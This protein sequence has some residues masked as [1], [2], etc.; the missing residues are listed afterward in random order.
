MTGMLHSDPAWA[1]IRLEAIMEEDFRRKIFTGSLILVLIVCLSGWHFRHSIMGFVHKFSL[2]RVS[3]APAGTI[4]FAVI[5]D[6]GSGS[7]LERNV[8]QMIDSWNPDFIATVG[9]N[10]YP[11]G[12][13]DTIDRNIGRFYHAYIFPYKG[14]FGS[15]ATT[16]RFFPIPG[17]RDWDSDMLRLYLDFF[18]LPDRK[19]HYDIVR[20]PV[21]LFMLDTDEREPDGATATSIQ[22]RWLQRRLAE[23][24]SPWNLVFAHHAPYTS[25]QVEDI[26]RMRWPFRE[27]GADAVLSGYY[28]VY[29]RL[30]VDGIPYFVNGAGGTWISHFGEIDPHS[31]FRYTGGFGAMLVDASTSRIIFRFVNSQG[32][33]ID[34]YVLEKKRVQ[35]EPNATVQH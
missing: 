12:A 3:P 6:Y 35:T 28:H 33:I 9:D 4:R 14:S 23:S 19:R 18:S 31:R 34:E 16:N 17:H 27:W 20:G 26:Y 29:E 24:T 22:G 21:H 8:A 5:G 7:P 1:S 30:L 25:H 11:D 15:G 13:A 32:Q 2:P 10:Y